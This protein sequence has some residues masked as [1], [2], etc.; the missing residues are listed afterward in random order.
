MKNSY[1]FQPR[2]GATIKFKKN[3]SPKAK[4]ISFAAMAF[5]IALGYLFQSCQPK[6]ENAWELSSPD[7]KLKISVSLTDSTATSLVYSISAINEN[8]TTQIVGPSPMGIIRADAQFAKNLSFVSKGEIRRI[9][10]TYPMKIGRNAEHHNLANE[11]EIN[12]KNENGALFQIVLRA[13]ND[14]AAFK[15]VFPDST[16]GIFTVQKDLTGFKIPETGKAWIQPYDLTTKWSPS[17]EQHYENGIPAGSSSPGSEGWALPALFNINN[18]WALIAEANLTETYCGGRFEQHAPGGLY[19]MRFPDAAEAEGVGSIE[20][21]FGLPWEMPWRCVIVGKSPGDIFN[22]ELVNNLSSNAAGDWSWVKPG[23]SSWSW[24]TDNDSPKS[25]EKLKDF[26]D[27]AA[28][29]KWEYS[30]V[31]TYWN[32]MK[33]G[34]L[35]QL[36]DYAHTKGVG[37][38]VWYNSGG[39]HT[40]SPEQPRDIMHDPD[41]RKAEFRKL[42]EWGV[43]GVKIDFWCSDKQAL[44]AQ[45]LEV[46]KDAAEY[47]LMVNFHGSTAPRGWSRTWPNLVS[48]EAVRGEEYY[49]FDPSMPERAPVQNTILPFTR[50]VAGP[51][52]YTPFLLSDLK[53]PHTTSF[54]HELALTVVF[55]SGIIHFADNTETYRKLPLFVKE[56]LTEVPATFDETRFISGLPGE[57]IIIA[58]RKGDNWYV[59]GINGQKQPKTVS[60]DLQ[61]LTEG[62]FALSLITDDNG[63]R[64]FA[65]QTGEFEKGGKIEVVMA[66]SGG[67]AGVLRKNN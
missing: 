59:A 65:H 45:Y 4:S 57:S 41:L 66:G 36:V 27:L 24:L 39:P 40:S 23:R 9:D 54:A 6:V 58:A 46:L 12:F 14:G 20:P 19:S 2:L 22:S 8:G 5:F 52:D 28:E 33:G 53:N 56:F 50:N 26:V 35:K 1:F 18:H 17:Y 64:D 30:L 55:N 11:W 13:Y 49:I 15:Y 29:M 21:S 34:D 25:F 62:K 60:L 37:M 67:F 43:K 31:D 16:A 32:Q 10:E 3:D 63:T 38:I 48:M 44:I 61:F 47:K 51:M 42:H 7:G